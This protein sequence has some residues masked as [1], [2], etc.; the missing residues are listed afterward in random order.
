MSEIFLLEEEDQRTV[1]LLLLLSSL[2]VGG[3]FGRLMIVLGAR[4]LGIEKANA[5]GT[6][7]FT[8]LTFLSLAVTSTA[9]IP[10]LIRVTKNGDR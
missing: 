9:K 4:R 7:I 2:A 6:V 10:N 3:W 8:R 1:F 5:V